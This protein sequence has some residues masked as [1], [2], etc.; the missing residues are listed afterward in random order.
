MFTTDK[1]KIQEKW[2][3]EAYPRQNSITLNNGFY[4]LFDCSEKEEKLT[5]KTWVPANDFLL[6]HTDICEGL[7]TTYTVEDSNNNFFTCGECSASGDDG[8]IALSKKDTDELVWLIV[9]SGTN[10][11]EKITFHNSNIHVQS[12]SGIVVIVP[13]DRPDNL[14]IAWT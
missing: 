2:L 1:H 5:K 10:P 3:E 11:F 6:D 8:F 7:S 14:S 9:L 4:C 13:I 12:S